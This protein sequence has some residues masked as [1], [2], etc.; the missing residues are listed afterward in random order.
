MTRTWLA[1]VTSTAVASLFLATAGATVGP[2]QAPRSDAGWTSLFDGQSLKGWRSYKK[3]DAA[4]T[5]W[6]VQDGVLTLSAADGRDTRGARDIITTDTFDRFELTWEWKISQAGNSGLKYYVLED[7]DSAIGHEYQIIDDERHPDA[8][9]G[10]ERQTSAFYDVM[11]PADRKLKPAGEWNT[12]RIVAN[13]ATVEHYLNGGRVLSYTLESPTLKTA[14]L[15]SK[16]KGI[17]RFGKLHK[18]HILLQDHGDQV[19]YRN[20]RIRRLSTTS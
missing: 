6:S 20:I 16:F 11:P 10:L 14:I 8:K 19:W 3:P 9:V 17:E 12:S 2:G 5:R 13:G 18:G 15:D 1:T 7:M 4:G